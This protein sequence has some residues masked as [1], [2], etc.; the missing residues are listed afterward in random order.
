[1]CKLYYWHYTKTGIDRIQDCFNNIVLLLNFPH[2]C[3]KGLTVNFLGNLKK[4]K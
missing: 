4:Q 1:M 2:P 3:Q